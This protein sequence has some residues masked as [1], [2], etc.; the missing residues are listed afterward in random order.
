[1]YTFLF[2]SKLDINIKPVIVQTLKLDSTS[3]REASKCRIKFDSKMEEMQKLAPLFPLLIFDV[4]F[5]QFLSVLEIFPKARESFPVLK[6]TNSE[7]YQ[8]V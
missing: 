6:I 7:E 8:V 1:M 5:A 2:C 4:H 3:P